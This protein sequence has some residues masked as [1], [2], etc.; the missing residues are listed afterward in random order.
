MIIRVI[1]GK[2]MK[3]LEAFKGSKPLYDRDGLLI[4]RGICRDRRFEEYNSIRDYLEDK[5]K[6]NGFEIVNDREDIELFVDK[7]DKKLRGN[8]NSIYPDAFGFERLKRS[9]E[10]MGC[11]CDYVIGRKGDIIVGISMW[12]DKVKKEPKFVEVICC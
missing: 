6:E 5:L 9:F 10:E 4:V 3:S 11:L 8:N 2:I 7:I 12:Y 1:T